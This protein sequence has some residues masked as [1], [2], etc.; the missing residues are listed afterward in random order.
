MPACTDKTRWHEMISP[1]SALFCEVALSSRET[2]F[3]SAADLRKSQMSPFN[4]VGQIL[5][6]PREAVNLVTQVKA[7]GRP[8]PPAV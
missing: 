1:P 5:G 4:S 7:I 8:F 2:E 6:S 3:L